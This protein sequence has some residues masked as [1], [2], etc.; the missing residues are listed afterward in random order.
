MLSEGSKLLHL[1]G[2]YRNSQRRG[3]HVK[4]CAVGF[5]RFLFCLFKL[6]CSLCN[7]E[8]SCSS[9]LSHL[10]LLFFWPQPSELFCAC[11]KHCYAIIQTFLQSSSELFSSPPKPLLSYCLWCIVGHF[12]LFELDKHQVFSSVSSLFSL[13]STLGSLLSH[14]PW[15]LIGFHYHFLFS[16]S[17]SV[18][19]GTASS[20]SS[21]AAALTD[22]TASGRWSFPGL[23]M[24]RWNMDASLYRQHTK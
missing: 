17:Q 20:S 6:W 24:S 7:K 16:L 8:D 12:F 9:L 15:L 22:F 4:M 23:L 3:E 18:W 2:G 5:R 10:P 21:T 19:K 1:G 13:S 11:V 14:P